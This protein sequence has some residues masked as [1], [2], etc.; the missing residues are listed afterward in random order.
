MIKIHSGV[1]LFDYAFAENGL[2]AYKLGKQLESQ[3]FIQWIGEENY[4]RLANF[5]LKYIADLKIPK[6]RLVLDCIASV[7]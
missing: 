7:G 3:S 4:Q 2:T 6:K 5:I 1:A